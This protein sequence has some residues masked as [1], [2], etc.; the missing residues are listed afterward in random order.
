MWPTFDCADVTV[1]GFSTVGRLGGAS[2]GLP[3][4][5]RRERDD[6]I[7]DSRADRRA[8]D[9]QIGLVSTWI[10][11]PDQQEGPASGARRGT[12]RSLPAPRCQ[13]A[14]G[15]VLA[16]CPRWHG[17]SA[18][19]VA[20]A[21]EYRTSSA[22]RRAHS[23]RPQ[24]DL[25][26]LPMGVDGRTKWVRGNRSP[27]THHRRPPA[28]G[29]LAFPEGA[30]GTWLGWGGQGLQGGDRVMPAAVYLSLVGRGHCQL[31]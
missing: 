3:V 24:V 21:A 11:A 9:A 27:R 7:T 31:G 22:G 1:A 29:W 4:R 18:S 25:G 2:A 30:A 14:A 17:G 19:S 5:R 23:V 6:E 10:G 13:P 15:L 12:Q 26:V 20:T 16:D 8:V 28:Y